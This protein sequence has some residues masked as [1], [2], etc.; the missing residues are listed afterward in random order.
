MCSCLGAIPVPLVL[1]TRPRSLIVSRPGS[2][3]MSGSDRGSPPM[4]AAGRSR[5]PGCGCTT[6]QCSAIIPS[7]SNRKKSAI[8]NA[9]S[10]LWRITKSPAA[11]NWIGL[12]SR[13]PGRFQATSCEIPAKSLSTLPDAGRVLDVV[14]G[15]VAVDQ[16]Q[17]VAVH[18][19]A[20]EVQ[21]DLLVRVRSLR[22]RGSHGLSS[23]DAQFP[24]A[25]VS[26]P[27]WKGCGIT[28]AR[29]CHRWL[30]SSVTIR[31]R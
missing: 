28:W 6:S 9:G 20:H 25:T 4:G 7:S 22:R 15:D 27:I 8:T 11:N 21:H 13:R 26:P 2:R 1:T 30:A 23:M 29:C 31:P 3:T 16:R 10:N 17:I 5:V 19:V 24:R 18:A 12:Q 14:L